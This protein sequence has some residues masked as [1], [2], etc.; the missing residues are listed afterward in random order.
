MKN[1]K[2]KHVTGIVHLICVMRPTTHPP[3]HTRS[4]SH[5]LHSNISHPYMNDIG[6]GTATTATNN[7][8]MRIILIITCRNYIVC[9]SGVCLYYY[10]YHLE[11]T[12]NP[13]MSSA[14]MII[15]LRWWP[16][17]C[18]KPGQVYLE[19]K[20][21]AK[22]RRQKVNRKT[23]FKDA[24]TRTRMQT[25]MYTKLRHHN[26]THLK[27][28]SALTVLARILWANF[29]THRIHCNGNDLSIRLGLLLAR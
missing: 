20:Y 4:H 25:R 27:P 7:K 6:T 19:T 9:R 16:W 3:T 24:H 26:T 1:I 13:L 22:W 18:A 23:L 14:L 21:R 8:I 15:T 10:Y 2:V 11:Y 17:W 5:W 29:S 12:N 28:H